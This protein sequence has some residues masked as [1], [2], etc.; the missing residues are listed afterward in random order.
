MNGRDPEEGEEEK[1]EEGTPSWIRFRMNPAGWGWG[2]G[3]TELSS[4]ISCFLSFTV[5]CRS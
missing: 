1:A 4:L 2:G 3:N 5:S